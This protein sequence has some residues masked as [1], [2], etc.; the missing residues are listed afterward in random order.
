[1][2]I[3]VLGGTHLIGPHA[4]RWLVEMGHEVNVVLDLI[5]GAGRDG[6]TLVGLFKGIAGRVVVVSSGD[7][8][9]AYDR[10]RRVD[11]G[12]PAP[13]PLTEDS[14]LRDRL[15]PYRDQARGP[16]DF[17]YSY[18]K[19]L[20]ERAVMSE[21]D[22]PATILRLPM[23]YGPG[24][25]QHRLPSYLKRMDDKRPAII[26]PRSVAGW[27]GL[28]Y[29]EPTLLDEAMRRSVAWERANPP[30]EFDPAKF[31]YAAEDA[32]LAAAVKG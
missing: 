24:D 20:V 5:P 30:D 2:R 22:L 14:P 31:D 6:K 13:T 7:V 18:E 8:S 32:A 25:Y 15:F 28:G 23:G 29:T 10:F 26:L 19:I 11:P 21:P 3:V 9:R 17:L 12:P 27:R 1:M 4:V 16:D